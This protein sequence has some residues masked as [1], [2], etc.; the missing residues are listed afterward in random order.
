[1]RQMTPAGPIRYTKTHSSQTTTKW[2]L[3]RACWWWCRHGEVVIISAIAPLYLLHEEGDRIDKE[4]KEVCPKI[5]LRQEVMLCILV[6]T[7]KVVCSSYITLLQVA[8]HYIAFANDAE[9]KW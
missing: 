5:F 3:G 9:T 4:S 8:F 6:H 1:M 7:M 2:I